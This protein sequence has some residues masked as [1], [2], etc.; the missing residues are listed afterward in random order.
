MDPRYALPR[1]SPGSTMPP[2][3]RRSAAASLHP[4][5]RRHEPQTE[6]MITVMDQHFDRD[7]RAGRAVLNAD[8]LTLAG[9]LVTGA[10]SAFEAL[11][12][13]QFSAPWA[14]P[15]SH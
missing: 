1:P 12:R 7:Y 3:T 9:K 2:F 6:R 14:A 10:K 5:A 15:R 8:V 13:T 4:C 11:N